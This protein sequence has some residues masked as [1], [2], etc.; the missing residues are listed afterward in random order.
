M[1]KLIILTMAIVMFA[2]TAFAGGLWDMVKNSNLKTLP[3]KAYQIE[4]KGVN[5]RVYVFKVPEMHSVCTIT[6]GDDTTS[7]MECKTYKEMGHE[8]R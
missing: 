6:Y 2:S 4:V 5:T 8:E 3:A 1:K 7:Q